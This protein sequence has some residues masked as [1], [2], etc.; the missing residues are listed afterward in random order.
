MNISP[1]ESISTTIMEFG[2]G[3]HNYR[4]TFPQYYRT[5]EMP[6]I[7]NTTKAYIDDSASI[8]WA[9]DLKTVSKETVERQMAKQVE[10]LNAQ[11]KHE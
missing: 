3:G 4:H 8:G 1:R 5:S 11:G 9:Y 7:F 6:L 10:I 2:E